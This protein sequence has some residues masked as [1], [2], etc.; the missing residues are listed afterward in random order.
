MNISKRIFLAYSIEAIANNICNICER[1]GVTLTKLKQEAYILQEIIEGRFKVLLLE[2]SFLESNNKLIQ[3]IRQHKDLEDLFI[4]IYAPSE[5]PQGTWTITAGSNVLLQAPF[6]ENKLLAIFKRAFSLPKQILFLTPN[7]KQDFVIALQKMGY[8]VS[9]SEN[10][11]DVISDSSP[12]IPDYI[13]AEYFLS[14]MTGLEFYQQIKKNERLKDVPCMLAYNGRNVNDIETIIKSNVENIIISPYSSATNLKKIQDLIPLSPKGKK[15]RA[16]V[17]D[18]SPII[19]SLIVTMFNELDYHVETAENGFEGYKAVENFNPDIITSDYDMPILDGWRF[20]TEVRDNQKYKDIPIIMITTRAN[21]LDLKKG[22]LLGVSAYLTKPFS[23]DQLKVAVET[24]IKNARLKKEQ[25]TIAKF[26]ASDTLKSI[27]NMVDGSYLKKG[28]DKFIT[29]LFTDICAFSLKCEKYSA[30]KIVLL[31][32]TYFDLMVDILAEHGAIIDKFIGDAIVARF[33]SGIPE[34]DA[35][36]AVYAAWRMLEKLIEFNKESFEE[37]QIRIG[38]NSG[39]VILGNLGSE[40]HRLEYAMIGDN[41]NI[42][43]RLESNAP[44]RGCMISESTYFLVKEK[45]VVGEKQEIKVKGKSELIS[46][47]ILEGIK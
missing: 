11:K 19:R 12:Q 1:Y 40:R 9:L 31:L 20:C 32:N 14:G 8:D 38:V 41:V 43:Q 2:Y 44:D 39:N 25:E 33:D 4:V 15:L 30:N 7:S 24:A 6:S 26:M 10:A 5:L 21:D 22:A 47:Y 46:A 27:N 36:N 34:I 17:V 42:G 28:E 13:I 23:K 29:I 3:Q 18:D 45:V 37:I 35:R 16:L